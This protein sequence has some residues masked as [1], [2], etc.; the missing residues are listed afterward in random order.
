M[1]F[2][3]QMQT[4]QLHRITE[5]TEWRTT[6]AALP[7]PHVLQSWEW[8]EAKAQTEW[9]AVRYALREQNGSLVAAFQLLLRRGP[10]GLPFSIG[11]IPKGPVVDWT[12]S[13][14]VKAT[15]DLIAKVGRQERS[16]FVK[17][18]PNVREDQ[19][20]GQ[21]LLQQLALGGW[22][23]SQEQIQFKNTAF[24]QIEPDHDSPEEQ[25]LAQI[26]NKWRYNI[27]L[28]KR[29]GIE[30]RQGNVTD[31]ASFY[32][33]YAETGERDA[34]LIRPYAYYKDV[35]GR[36]LAAQDDLDNP[37]GGTLLL[38]EHQEE[39]SA[40]AG[41]FLMRYGQRT[42]YFY[43]ASSNRRRRDMPNHL[44]QW[45]A[46]CWAIRQGSTVYD[47]WGAP[48][49]PDDPDD[50]LAGVWRFKQGFGA[51]LQ[52]HVGAWD[53]VTSPLLFAFYNRLM[54]LIKR[55]V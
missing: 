39:P 46:L 9:R 52:S 42:W 50:S 15:L 6:L 55:F 26:K 32:E 12:Q 49:N 17:I 33:L 37:A 7:E 51:Q 13:S 8:G 4:T 24:S 21:Q 10:A 25:L 36:Y 30:V 44:L 38:A 14:H 48:T 54:P 20:E 22:K 16:L 41:L 2:T 5:A 27:R 40:I 1:N 11:Y 34:F 23:V 43:G 3:N 35:W 19:P 18:D 28:A 29:R 31:L 47:W 45:E 53:L